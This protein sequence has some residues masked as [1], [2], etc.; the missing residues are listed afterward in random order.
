MGGPLRQAVSTVGGLSDYVNV[1]LS[2]DGERLLVTQ[3]VAG[4]NVRSL[5]LVDLLRGVPLRFTL[6]SNGVNAGVFSPDGKKVAYSSAD[7]SGGILLREAGGAGAA[8]SLETPPP[9]TRI[10]DWSRDGRYLMFAA[11]ATGNSRLWT[12]DLAA[13]GADRRPSRYSEESRGVSQGQ[14]SPETA[15]PPHW[16]AYTSGESG[17]RQEIYVQSFPGGAAKFQISNGGGSQPRWRRDGRELFYIAA[18]GKLMAVD[19]KLT[20][21]FQP[22]IPHALFES[23]ARQEFSGS[24]YQYD[25]APDGLR[26]LFNTPRLDSGVQ[27]SIT[28]ELNWLAGV[29]K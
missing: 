24:A 4:E 27:E 13:A 22:G 7:V 16:V 8:E 11:G 20:P 10:C 6:D 2:R 21:Q 19:V 26:F 1:A 18:D 25:V 3:S 12:M 17:Q 5:W 28:V 9:L 29:R 15:G 14:F 23:P